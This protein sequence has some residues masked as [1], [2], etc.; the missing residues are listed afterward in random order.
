MEFIATVKGEQFSFNLIND[1]MILITGK[2]KAYILYKSRKWNCADDIPEGLL[3][4][5]GEIIDEH[6]QIH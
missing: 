3:K 2:D 6:L 5:F 1:K 4:K